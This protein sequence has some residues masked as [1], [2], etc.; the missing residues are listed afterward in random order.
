VGEG[1]RRMGWPD[2]ACVVA[3]TMGTQLQLF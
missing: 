3:D 1:F 2:V